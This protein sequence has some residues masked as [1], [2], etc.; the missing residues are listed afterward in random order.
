MDNTIGTPQSQHL[1]HWKAALLV[2]IAQLESRAEDLVGYPIDAGENYV[3]SS[4]PADLESVGIELPIALEAFYSKIGEVS[5]PD[6]HIGY[7]IHAVTTILESAERSLPTRIESSLT[8]DVVTFGS[9]GGGGLFALDVA[10]GR[11]YFLPSGAI[12]DGVYR[13]GLDAVRPIAESLESFLDVLLHNV[14][15]FVSA[16]NV[17]DF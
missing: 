6:M 3:A 5:L 7:F 16:G 9:D 8:A 10:Y 1:E 12:E 11:V 4:V 15:A 2:A 17:R 14:E 13:G